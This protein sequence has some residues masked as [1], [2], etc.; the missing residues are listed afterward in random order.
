MYKELLLKSLKESKNCEFLLT[1]TFG[2][3]TQ[4]FYK[5]ILKDSTYVLTKCQ[6][7]YL[8]TR[9]FDV[10]WMYI[11]FNMRVSYF[12]IFSGFVFSKY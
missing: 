2:I 6:F 10:G 11:R 4:A 7:T 1:T 12:P 9:K 3:F 8:M 5:K